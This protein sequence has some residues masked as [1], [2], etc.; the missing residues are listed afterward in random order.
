MLKITRI[1]VNYNY[2]V[3]YLINTN[4]MLLS[5]VSLQSPINQ[6]KVQ[7]IHSYLG[8]YILDVK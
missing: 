4:V 8:I 3:N 5:T 7:N 6:K 1:C 2:T